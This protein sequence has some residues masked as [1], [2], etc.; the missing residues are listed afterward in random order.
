MLASCLLISSGC[1]KPSEVRSAPMVYQGVPAALME[2][3][4]VRDVE[5][6]TTGDLVVSRNIWKAG[7]EV[8]SARIDAIR[9][10][11]AQARAAQ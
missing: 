5:L 9:K 3:C 1:S 4:V 10:H 6:N 2:R 8:C 7:Q 11:D